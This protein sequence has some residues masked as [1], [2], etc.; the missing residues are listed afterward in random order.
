MSNNNNIIYIVTSI[1]TNV[2]E[3]VSEN[4]KNK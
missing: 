2:W 4:I 1:G 3:K